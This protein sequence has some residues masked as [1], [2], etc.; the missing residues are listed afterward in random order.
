[1]LAI[2]YLLFACYIPMKWYNSINPVVKYGRAK[3]QKGIQKWQ[4]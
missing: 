4:Y 3:K 1:V 2:R